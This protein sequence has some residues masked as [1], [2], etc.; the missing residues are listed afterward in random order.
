MFY[1]AAEVFRLSPTSTWPVMTAPSA[2]TSRGA[3]MSPTTEPVA[4]RSSCSLALTF[5]VT[6]PLIV[7]FFAT[8]SALIVALGRMVKLW[9]PSSIDPSTW[10]SIVKSSVLMTLPSTRTD[11]PIHPACRRSVSGA[12]GSVASPGRTRSPVLSPFLAGNGADRWLGIGCL[13]EP[14]CV[15]M[16]SPERRN[17]VMSRIRG[18]NP[19]PELMVRSF[20]HARARLRGPKQN[21][22]CVP[23]R[24]P[25]PKATP[26]STGS[27]CLEQTTTAGSG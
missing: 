26:G 20:L 19:R 17:E 27:A 18:R 3:T 13:T 4:R 11:L 1:S 14:I 9:S 2:M 12:L 24:R 21:S 23:T 15:D 10:P 6:A 8:K 16:L 7:M 25:R 22:P 5:P